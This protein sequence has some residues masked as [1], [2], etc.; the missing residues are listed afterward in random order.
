M[1]NTCTQAVCYLSQKQNLTLPLVTF[2]GL[3]DG[4]N[5]CAIAMLVFLLGYL[6]IFLQRK[7]KILPTAI[8]YILTVY[9]TYFIVGFVLYKLSIFLTLSTWKQPLGRIFSLLFL[10]FAA[11]TLKDAFAPNLGPNLRIP[12]SVQKKLKNF[13][14]RA[15]YPATIIFAILVT[16]FKAPCSLP[17][18]AGTAQVLASSGLP[19]PVILAYLLYYNLL[20]VLPLIMIA[21]VFVKGIDYLAIEDFTHR[22]QPKMKLVAGLS[23]LGF[24]LYFWFS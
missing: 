17:L 12:L 19:K 10:F 6:L 13:V 11:W 1:N 14:K 7:D 20:F 15:N 23:L 8:V 4:L 2:A 3:I 16:L 22:A 18:Y 24:G 9:L 5:P 21:G